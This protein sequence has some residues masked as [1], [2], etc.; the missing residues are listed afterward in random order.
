ME[1]GWRS[2]RRS[3]HIVPASGGRR[4]GVKWAV[5]VVVSISCLLRAAAGEAGSL[6]AGER[7]AVGGGN[8][9]F[10]RQEVRTLMAA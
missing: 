1:R 10:F 5:P 6:A 4:R 3:E 7:E 2:V 8:L 9:F